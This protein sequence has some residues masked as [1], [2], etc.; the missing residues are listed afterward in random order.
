VRN[1]R[2]GNA[3]EMEG[4]EEQ[5]GVS[6]FS[7]CKLESYFVKKKSKSKKQNRL[8]DCLYIAF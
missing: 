4:E 2:T 1:S 8:L 5:P 3:M 6:N 7:N